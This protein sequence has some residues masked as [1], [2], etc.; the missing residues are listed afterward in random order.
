MNKNSKKY[1]YVY[2]VIN[3]L[4]GMEYIGVHSTDNINDGYFGSGTYL[5]NAIK[6]YG[7]NSFSKEIIHEFNDRELALNKEQELVNPNYVK[8]RTVYNLVLGG[9]APMGR[10]L[11]IRKFKKGE[12]NQLFIDF[13]KEE[14]DDSYKLDYEGDKLIFFSNKIKTN[15]YRKWLE[16]ADNN[17]EIYRRIT[18]D[19][20][21][22]WKIR[23]VISSFIA[24]HID[25][26]C[27]SLTK[28]YN[29]KRRHNIAMKFI[30]Q[31]YRMKWLGDY[32]LVKKMENVA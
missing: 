28:C 10:I 11:S 12:Q 23:M 29:D 16:E 18:K 5:R 26:T 2:K 17:K 7:K 8:N 4:N 31:L 20:P 22:Q 27:E 15:D 6:K 19:D 30:N 13:D 24:N 14:S 3:N 9:G 1:H 21:V 25:D 32:V